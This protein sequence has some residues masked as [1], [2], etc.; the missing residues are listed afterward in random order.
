MM[1][2]R[3]LADK[4]VLNVQEGKSTETQIDIKGNGIKEGTGVDKNSNGGSNKHITRD[5]PF[6]IRIFK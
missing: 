4:I 6:T 1:V 5:M 3:R 2:N